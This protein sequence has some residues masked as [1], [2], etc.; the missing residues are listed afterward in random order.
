MY[1]IAINRIRFHLTPRVCVRNMF[2]VRS[3]SYSHTHTRTHTRERALAAA[4]RGCSNILH[5][6]H[7][8]PRLMCNLFDMFFLRGIM[9]YQL[10]E[11]F[12]RTKVG[13]IV[14]VCVSALVH[15]GNAMRGKVVLLIAWHATRVTRGTCTTPSGKCARFS[16]WSLA[17]IVVGLAGTK[18]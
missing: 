10:R 16:D 14:C 4:E 2:D 13:A 17:P 18:I 6:T 11:R 8:E 15:L 7:V 9:S 3:Q 5:Q 1:T 12:V